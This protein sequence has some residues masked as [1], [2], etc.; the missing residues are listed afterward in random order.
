MQTEEKEKTSLKRLS[1][2]SSFDDTSH[3]NDGNEQLH[4][5]VDEDLDVMDSLSIQNNCR[6]TVRS[7]RFD[8]GSSASSEPLG[9]ND[10]K[11]CIG[12]ENLVTMTPLSTSLKNVPKSKSVKKSHSK[13]GSQKKNSLRRFNRKVK[14][15]KDSELKESVSNFSIID[16]DTRRVVNPLCDIP[17]VDGPSQ[18]SEPPNANDAFIYT[19]LVFSKEN[20][21]PLSYYA[22][23]LG[24]QV[25]PVPDDQYV[26]LDPDKI[27][28]IWDLPTIPPLGITTDRINEYSNPKYFLD[29][30]Y[31]AL[32]EE[33]WVLLIL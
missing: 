27:S 4:L 31:A 20:T 1:E 11:E 6:K 29:P 22:R 12:R 2:H 28:R 23:L 17:C 33:K 8:D 21:F 26:T 5:R 10:H 32:L 19:D 14:P 9:I 3:D 18:T 25:D 15:L 30:V 16:E 13:A 24:F 7:K